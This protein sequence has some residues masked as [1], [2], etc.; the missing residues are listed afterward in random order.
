MIKLLLFALLFLGPVKVSLAEDIVS[1]ASRDGTSIVARVYLPANVTDK[2]P[3]IVLLHGC[4]G[5]GRKDGALFPRHA[6]WAKRFHAAGFVVVLPDSFGSRALGSQCQVKERAIRPAG[7]VADAFG[8]LDYLVSRSDVDASRIMVMGWSN[9][10]STV[11]RVAGIAPKSP[12]FSR[13]IAFYPGC[14]PLV[15]RSWAAAIP[16]D[17]FHGKADDW[18]PIAPCE[19]LSRSGD[20]T[21][22]AYADAHH[23]FDAPGLPLRR[24]EG[25]AFTGNGDGTAHLGTHEPA[26][27]AAIAKVMAIALEK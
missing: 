12:R 16:L 27:Q 25:L 7:R 23:D 26:R 3:A 4:G 15:G 18:T 2:L 1:F 20:F 19:T 8:A 11:L 24:R 21:L 6:D 17:V 13:A 10:G 5:L 14:R 9:G 22:H